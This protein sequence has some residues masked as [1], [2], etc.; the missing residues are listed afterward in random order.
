MISKKIFDMENF[1]K[2]KFFFILLFFSFK[3]FALDFYYLQTGI[4]SEKDKQTITHAL[5][6]LYKTYP[7]DIDDSRKKYLTSLAFNEVPLDYY[8][9]FSIPYI[10]TT[11]VR[12][13]IWG[14]S[15]GIK[16]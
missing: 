6:S 1:M 2:Q 9:V 7:D 16:K 11:F 5:Q 12:S 10:E 4:Y 15:Q 14:Y 8:G 13:F 3:T